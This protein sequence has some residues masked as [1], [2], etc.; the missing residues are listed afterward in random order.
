RASFDPAAPHRCVWVLRQGEDFAAR[1]EAACRAVLGAAPAPRRDVFYGHGPA[2]RLAV[3]FPGQG[4][5]RVGMLRDLAV[6]C[7]ALL[8]ALEAAGPDIATRIYPP[9]RFDPDAAADEGRTLRR[10]DIAQPALGAVEWGA[11]RLLAGW[12][13][14]PVAAA[15]HSFGELVALAAAGRLPA[16]ALP[17]LAAARG[18]IMATRTTDDPGTMLAVSMPL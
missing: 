5:Q 18:R 1:R 9:A 8:D 16:E 3:L 12:G 11:W 2:P 14:G 13:L 4:A 15:G 17:G 10:T 6:R 7:P